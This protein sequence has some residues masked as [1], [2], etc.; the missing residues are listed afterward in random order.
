[1]MRTRCSLSISLSLRVL[2]RLNALAE[3][4]STTVSGVIGSIL[5]Q[6][7]AATEN[8]LKAVPHLPASTARRP[9]RRQS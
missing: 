6:Y 8:E 4:R 9:E 7:F 3:E 5:D 2:N 1:M